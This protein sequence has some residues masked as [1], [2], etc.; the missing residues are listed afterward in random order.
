M[1][2]QILSQAEVRTLVPTKWHGLVSEL[3]DKLPDFQKLYE[4]RANRT[5][6]N[7]L[8]TIGVIYAGER[9][10]ALR[11]YMNYSFLPELEDF[12]QTLELRS[13]YL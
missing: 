1:Q 6:R 8:P 3:F 2:N 13:K 7:V 12:L 5:Q 9:Q 4:E 10:K 11:I